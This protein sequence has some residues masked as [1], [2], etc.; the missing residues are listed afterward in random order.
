MTLKYILLWNYANSR[1]CLLLYY[2]KMLF[3]GSWN[4]IWEPHSLYQLS[5]LK[6]FSEMCSS[7]WVEPEDLLHG[8]ALKST[9][10]CFKKSR[11]VPDTFW[12][13][14]AKEIKAQQPSKIKAKISQSHLA[15]S[16]KRKCWDLPKFWTQEK[17]PSIFCCQWGK[18]K[19]LESK[20]A[21]Q[22]NGFRR[23]NW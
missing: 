22:G 21:P 12:H 23:W 3:I 11:W 19:T 2:N 18:P 16:G 6:L 4:K 7:C 5:S 13:P 20:A 15:S 8:V 1:F 9:S 17:N 10:T 14:W